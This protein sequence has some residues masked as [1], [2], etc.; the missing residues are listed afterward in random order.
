MTT[1]NQRTQL[2]LAISL[3]LVFALGSIFLLVL[4]SQLVAPTPTPIYSTGVTEIDPPRLVAD[5]TLPGGDGAPL[6]LSALRGKYTLLFFGYTHC[7]DFCPLTLSEFKR[8][9]QDLAEDAAQVQF[10]FI[11][12]DGARDT[13]DMMS[14]YAARFDPEFLVMQG[15]E[16]TL[17]QISADYNLFYTL[18]TDEGEN[19]SV[20]HTTPS[21][22]ID[23]K[24]RLAVIY[25]FSA[26]PADITESIRAHLAS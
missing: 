7:P 3:G 4:R 17:S 8:I 18:N 26:E 23:P 12:V 21:Y 10:L 22:L 14:A 13:P 9:K 11:S 15:S 25:S 6:A 2:I 16:P 5:F 24:G 1:P 19:Y 20:D